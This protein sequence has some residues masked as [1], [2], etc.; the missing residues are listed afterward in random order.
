MDTIKAELCKIANILEKTYMSQ[1]EWARSQMT[2]MTQI[3]NNKS[4][5]IK[6]QED[7]EEIGAYISN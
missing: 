4:S 1:L 5:P 6:Q 7:R 3:R 2:K